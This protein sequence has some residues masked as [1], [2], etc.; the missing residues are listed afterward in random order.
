MLLSDPTPGGVWSSGIPAK[1]SVTPT[2]LVTCI[3]HSELNVPIYYTMPDGCRAVHIFKT[4]SI[5]GS[6]TGPSKVCLGTTIMLSDTTRNGYWSGS[7]SYA[8][9]DGSGDVTGLAVGTVGV[10]FT[11]TSTGCRRILTLTI[12]PLPSTINGTLSVCTGSV[13]FVSDATIPGVSWTSGNPAVATI[14]YSGGVTGIASGTAIITYMAANTCIRTAVVTVNPTPG[15]VAPILGPSTISHTGG[16]VTLTDIT[17]GGVWSSSN[18]AILTVGSAT[19]VTTAVASL[20]SANINYIVTNSYGCRNFATK[21]ISTSP[22]PPHPSGSSTTTVGSTVSL[23][24]GVTGGEWVS[25]DNSVTT[26]DGDGTVTG[27]APGTAN[28]THTFFTS[29]GD[30]SATITQIVVNPVALE[31]TMFPNPNGGSFTVHGTIGSGKDEGITLE[32]TDMLGT[33]VYSATAIAPAGVINE[34]INLGTGL[35]NGIYLLTVK[36]KTASKM[37]RFV[38]EGK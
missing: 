33:R 12:N 24:D 37:L 1:A 18:T 15:A 16:P 13:T 6:I 29:D 11:S 22:A 3:N 23:T 7:T 14:S 8:T 17:P 30:Q 32:I 38:V 20:G 19:G 36:S 25:S 10:T 4:D 9:I 2:G 5:P 31:V 21:V 26:L 27:I 35:E 34:Q 28:I